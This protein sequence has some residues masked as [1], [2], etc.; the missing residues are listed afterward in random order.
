MA[1]SSG[2]GKLSHMQNILTSV[3]PASRST[4]TPNGDHAI[5]SIHLWNLSFYEPS[6]TWES[7]LNFISLPKGFLFGISSKIQ[8]CG[9]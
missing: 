3:N 5:E 7:Q 4:E 6:D 8:S 9:P 2:H 1:S